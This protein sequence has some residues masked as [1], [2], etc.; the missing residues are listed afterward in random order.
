[1][2]VT[3]SITTD[4]PTNRSDSFAEHRSV[5]TSVLK[6]YRWAT[7]HAEDKLWVDP[8]SM[9]VKSSRSSWGMDHPLLFDSAE[10]LSE[11]PASIDSSRLRLSD[12]R[13]GFGSQA[14]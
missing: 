8:S 10:L 14:T 13:A 2:A 3:C 4:E 12:G 9:P 6:L 5:V 11:E 7:V 1:M